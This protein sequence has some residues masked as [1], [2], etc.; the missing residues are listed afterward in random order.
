L[1]LENPQSGQARLGLGD[2][3]SLILGIVIGTSIF[4][5][6]PL[7]MG[8]VSGPW[9]GL[10]VWALGGG[11]ALIGAL[12]YAELASTYPRSGGDYVYLS[13]AFGPWAGFLFGWSRLS[14]VVTANI[15]AMAFVFAD[16]ALD[17]WQLPREWG[18]W[19]AAGAVAV[20]TAM[21]LFG[22][23]SG[24]WTQNVLTV[25]KVVGLGGVVLAGFCWSR[26]DAW[27]VEQPVAEPNFGLAMILVLYAYGGWNDAACV[28][29]DL[30]NRRDIARALIAGTA[31]VLVIYLVLNAAYVLGLG[32]EGVRHSKAAVA[33]RVLER[34]LGPW[35]AHAMSV[36]VMV[37]ALGAINAMIFTG[38][39][40]YA[41]LG[42]EHSLFACLGRWHP[43]FGSPHWALL[44]QALLSLL[45]I[46]AVGT[47]QGCE[48]IDWLLTSCGL[49]R[50]PW[51]KYEGGFNTLVAG[52]A[53]VFWVFFLLTGLSLFAL[54][55]RDPETHRP[56][57]VPFFPVL[58]LVFCG[59]CFYMLHAALSYAENL[60]LLGFVPLLLGLPL[61]LISRRQVP[62][63]GRGV[64]K[65]T[66]QATFVRV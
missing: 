26:P 25:L 50:L 7:I 23:Q 4:R 32:F 18:F 9:A 39:R 20:L 54:R 1:S 48:A 3:V 12:C 63:G 6:P 58:P 30:R 15:G 60:A 65:E 2:T 59:T 33:A 42:A 22:V 38:S 36:L 46:S 27:V 5:S 64:Y 55:E 13:R 34:P 61:Y 10:G 51:E 31:G 29:A 56:F 24:K 47:P 62:P 21:N 43:R 66:E 17:L 19:F 35:A 57:S 52:T 45:M 16:Y 49:S 37:S 40:V 44:T 28:A 14:V 53:P 8:N 11:L 41:S